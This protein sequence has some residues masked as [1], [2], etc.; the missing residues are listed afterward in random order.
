[1]WAAPPEATCGRSGLGKRG[2]VRVRGQKARNLELLSRENVEW[3][4]M[5]VGI[6]GLL[7][8]FGKLMKDGIVNKAKITAK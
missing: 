8:R 5:G 4:E 6:F 3:Q 7:I 1:M 2:A